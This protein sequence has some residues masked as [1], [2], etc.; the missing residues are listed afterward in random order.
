[1]LPTRDGHETFSCGTL[2]LLMSFG[3][4]NLTVV[5]IRSESGDTRVISRTA[6]SIECRK[7]LYFLDHT[8]DVKCDSTDLHFTTSMRTFISH[9]FSVLVAQWLGRR[10][11]D[12]ALAGSI[13]GLG[14]IKSPRST[15]PS[16][17]PG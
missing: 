7:S 8:S 6:E 3:D 9:F 17:P 1:M 2:L 15:Q 16:I 14:A 13:H 10:T 4:T 5:Y 12:Q 11:F